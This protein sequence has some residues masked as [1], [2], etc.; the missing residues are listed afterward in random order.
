MPLKIIFEFN[1]ERTLKNKLK[2]IYTNAL[3]IT[4]FFTVI[5][6]CRM[7]K[8]S[9]KNRVIEK[10]AIIVGESLQKLSI[11]K[12]QTRAREQPSFN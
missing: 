4:A 2:Y 6:V 11:I 5:S 8:D 10:R 12:I 3:K 7:L 9:I 1:S